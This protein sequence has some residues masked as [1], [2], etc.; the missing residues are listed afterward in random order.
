M[1]LGT[2]VAAGDLVAG[3]YDE[4]VLATGVTPRTPEIAGI[5]HPKVLSYADVLSRGAAV[6][7]RVAIVGAGG[8]GFDVAEFLACERSPALD[9]EAWFEEWGVDPAVAT[10]GGVEGLSKRTAPANRTIYLLQRKRVRVGKRL[11]K[12]SG[13]VHRTRLADEGVQMLSGVQYTRIADAGLEIRVDDKAR[14]LEVDHVVVCA[15]QEPLRDLEAGLEAAGRSS[16]R[17]GGADVAA[18]LDAK[19]AILQAT[20]LAARL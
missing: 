16:H 3:G 19:R 8:I 4:I 10:R 5:D 7:R 17:V 6:G 13:W 18:E 1:R 9:A 20:Q 12:T 11:G 15:G 2:R 14:W